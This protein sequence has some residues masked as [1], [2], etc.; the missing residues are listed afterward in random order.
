[1]KEH[2]YSKLKEESPAAWVPGGSCSCAAQQRGQGW[3]YGGQVGAG[4][5]LLDRSGLIQVGAGS[6]LLDREQLHRKSGTAALAQEAL[7]ARAGMA[8][9]P[10]RTRRPP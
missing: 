2:T 3:P 8:P 5:H 4:S 7:L 10:R 6:H 1:M 9:R